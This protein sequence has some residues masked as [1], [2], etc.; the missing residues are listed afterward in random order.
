MPKIFFWGQCL[1]LVLA[2]A[3]ALAQTK[4][5]PQERFVKRN[6]IMINGLVIGAV[7]VG[8]ERLLYQAGRHKFFGGIA[9]TAFPVLESDA[10]FPRRWGWYFGAGLTAHYSITTSRRTNNHHFEMGFH[11]QFAQQDAIYGIQRNY[12]FDPITLQRT[13]EIYENIGWE[14]L[15][16]HSLAPTIGYRYQR[17]QGGFT[18]RAGL[19]PFSVDLPGGVYGFGVEFIP[20]P[21]ASVGWSF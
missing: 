1:A 11:H 7:G 6:S 9:A 13:N 2:A 14:K 3:P 17:P 19:R 15:N 5:D 8:Y 18:W 21:Y 4:A 10:P 20:F 12:D 16:F